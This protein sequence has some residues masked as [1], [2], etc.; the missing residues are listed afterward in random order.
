MTENNGFGRV[1][2]ENALLICRCLRSLGCPPE[3]V[4]DIVQ[5]TFVKALLHIEDY[6]GEGSISAWL[7]RI[8]RNL[9]YDQAARQKREVPLEWEEARE[10]SYGFTWTDLIG[11]LREP[12]RGVFSARALWGWS[13]AEVA[14]HYSRNESWARV[15][16]YRARMQLQNMLSAKEEKEEDHEGTL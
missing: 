8:A 9:W 10:D 2:Q 11:R 3:D 6:R 14:G 7:C 16:Y 13:Y 15:T 12:Y 4:E 5:E 1:Y